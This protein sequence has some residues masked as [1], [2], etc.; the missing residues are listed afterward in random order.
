MD[1]S[2]NA[3]ASSI[4][5]IEARL[6]RIEQSLAKV[7]QLAL[8]GE[9]L[10]AVASDVI[11]RSNATGISMDAR[12]Q[13]LAQLV[14]QGTRPQSTQALT[15]LARKAPELPQGAA[16]LL[17]I[18]DSH[19]AQHPELPE[20][21]ATLLELAQKLGSPPQA[22]ALSFA[23]E[24]LSQTPAL[25]GTLADILDGYAA[26]SDPDASLD[27][28]LHNLTTLL[29]WLAKDS[30]RELLEAL[31]TDATAMQTLAI[32]AS[33]ASKAAQGSPRSLGLLGALGKLRGQDAGY[34]LNF[35]CE[36]LQ[37]LGQGLKK[38]TP[39]LPKGS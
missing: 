15:E 37:S 6:A 8:Q 39:S 36:L 4:E 27:N 2:K 38:R 13:Q 22:K 10:V 20:R 24:Q 3:A 16:T 34:A 12:I 14:E 31:P 30:T 25:L 17:D 23:L 33:S 11:D 28:V 9:A 18:L 21:L 29:G 1:A 5:Q 32:L 19:I 35:A 7:E 26:Q